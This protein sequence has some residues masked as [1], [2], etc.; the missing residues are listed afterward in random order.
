LIAILLFS[1]TLALSSDA[2]VETRDDLIHDATERML[3]GEELSRDIDE[4]L[5]HLA[6]ADRIEVL[7]FLRR[8]G[9]LSGPSWSADRLLAPVTGKEL[10]E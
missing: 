8:S 9:M 10:A 4:R 1:S 6:P 5:M 7:I 2:R 3:N